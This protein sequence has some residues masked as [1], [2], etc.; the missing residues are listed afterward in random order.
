ME[1]TTVASETSVSDPSPMSSSFTTRT[2]SPPSCGTVRSGEA[3]RVGAQ[4]KLPSHISQV[5]ALRGLMKVH[6]GQ[7]RWREISKSMRVGEHISRAGLLVSGDASSPGRLPGDGSLMGAVLLRIMLDALEGRGTPPPPGGSSSPSL[8]NPSMSRRASPPF[9]HPDAISCVS[10]RASRSFSVEDKAGTP[11]PA[12]NSHTPRSRFS[13]TRSPGLRSISPSPSNGTSRSSGV[14]ITYEVPAP[15][16]HDTAKCPFSGLQR[17]TSCLRE[18]CLLAPANCRRPT[19]V[20]PLV[21][22]MSSDRAHESD[23]SPHLRRYADMLRG[24][25]RN[26]INEVQRLL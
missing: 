24:R 9:S 25:V 13:V 12:T 8:S 19:T 14:R 18:T 6:C 22:T 4:T 17:K 5:E 1:S 23:A 26:S 2:P 3:R 20:S 11:V 7:C 21:R 16:P 15:P 10:S